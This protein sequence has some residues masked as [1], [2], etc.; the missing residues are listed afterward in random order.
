MTKKVWAI[1]IIILIIAIFA[2]IVYWHFGSAEEPEPVFFGIS[3]G[4]QNASEAKLLIDKVKN[5]TNFFIIDSWDLATNET[6]LT[7]VCDYAA[8]AGLDFM[9]YFSFVSRVVYPW[10]QTWLGMAKQRWGDRFLGVYLFDEPGGNQIDTGGWNEDV[11]EIFKTATNYSDAANIFVESLSSINST[12]DLK[13]MRIPMFTSDYALYWFDYLAGY[14]TIFVEMAWNH[15]RPQQ[16]GLCRGAANV[17]GK[18]WGAIIT[19]TYD[20]PPYMASGPRILDDM[21]IAYAAGARYVIVFNYYEIPD[22]NP[23]GTLGDEHFLAMQQ[24][25]AFIHQ[26]PE[27]HGKTEGNVALVLPKDYGSG[28]RSS[29]DSIWGLWPADSLSSVIWD[30]MNMLTDE[31]GLRLDIVYNDSRFALTR[32]SKIY[33]WNS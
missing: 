9:V 10:H 5:Y 23:Y 6:A 4:G 3:F 20:T 8:D 16:I 2:P 17:Q 27:D 12:L 29:N 30:K 21:L 22:N 28:L 18:E 11:K 15:S 14:D 25:W 1:L 19:W 26:H 24:F 33:Y 31:Y 13:R 32:Y 7:E